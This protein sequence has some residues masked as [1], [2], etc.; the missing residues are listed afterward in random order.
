[1]QKHTNDNEK[2][3]GKARQRG[4][5]TAA[6]TATAEAT[7]RATDNVNGYQSEDSNVSSSHNDNG[8]KGIDNEGCGISDDSE[9]HHGIRTCKMTTITT[10]RGTEATTGTRNIRATERRSQ[11][12]RISQPPA[13][14]TEK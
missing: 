14:G 7:T 8:H 12:R 2:D 11:C 4:S 3:D 9:Y 13:P 1:M 5:G 10:G 6:R